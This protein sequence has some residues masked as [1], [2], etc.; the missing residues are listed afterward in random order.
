MNGFLR[1][2]QP[3]AKTPITVARGKIQ[4]RASEKLAL[5][6]G[7]LLAARVAQMRVCVPTGSAR[8]AS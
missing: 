5:D 7:R 4:L 1:Q 6:D 2:H 8:M 3:L